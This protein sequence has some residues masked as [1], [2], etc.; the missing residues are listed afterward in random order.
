MALTEDGMKSY[1][2]YRY[3]TAA[4]SKTFG[5]LTQES[6]SLDED[7]RYYYDSKD[8]KLLATV[9]FDEDTGVC[10]TY[11]GMGKNTDH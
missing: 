7:I 11:D 8:G 1:V 10:Y 3:D 2:N 6:N 5:A 9:N 4:Q